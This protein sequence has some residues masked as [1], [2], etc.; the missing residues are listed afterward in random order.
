MDQKKIYNGKLL[1]YLERQNFNW[2]LSF[3]HRSRH[4]F[5]IDFVKKQFNRSDSL[6]ILDLGCG[7]GQL[8]E[9]I[10]EEFRSNNFKY[11]GV[12][13]SSKFI[14]I[15][16]KLVDGSNAT[17]IKQEVSGFIMSTETDSQIICLL[18]VV[19]HMSDSEFHSLISEL[20][21]KKFKCIIITVPNETGLVL[22][23]KNLIACLMGYKRFKEYSLIENL[24][25]LFGRWE[26]IC[27]I[28]RQHKG[29][30]WW[31]TLHYLTVAFPRRVTLFSV[32]FSCLPRCLT[33]TIGFVIDGDSD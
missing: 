9:L 16:R 33:P 29:Y 23:L 26:N 1:S 30:K 12:D 15:A 31:V 25:I 19:E 8:L 21:K 20:K 28:A 6:N 2:L 5:I 17:I 24:N 10:K 4:K 32:P 22:V 7:P 3:H 13:T 14:E 27:P 11:T 18:E